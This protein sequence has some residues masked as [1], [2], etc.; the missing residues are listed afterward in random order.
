MFSDNVNVFT[1]HSFI[2]PK[3]I[4]AQ[5]EGLEGAIGN[6]HCRYGTKHWNIET[7]R[8]QI[9]FFEGSVGSQRGDDFLSTKLQRVLAEIER[10]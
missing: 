8:A 3:V 9:K 6:E 2:G 5:V 1:H 10:T 4:L 7:T